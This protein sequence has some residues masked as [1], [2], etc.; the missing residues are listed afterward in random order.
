MGWGGGRDNISYYKSFYFKKKEKFIFAVETPQHR[1][2]AN[3]CNAIQPQTTGT[4]TCPRIDTQ[5]NNVKR[6]EQTIQRPSF[7]L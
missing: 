4:S 6:N 2:P 5:D 1:Q 7:T 3:P